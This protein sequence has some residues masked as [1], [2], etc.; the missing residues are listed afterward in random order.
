MT[1]VT[2]AGAVG[3]ARTWQPDHSAFPALDGIRALA[4]S[5]VVMTHAAF[6][7]YRY[8][9]GPGSGMLARLDSGVALFF[10]LSGFLLS[11]PWLVAAATGRPYPAV[12]VY[13]WRRARRILPIYWLSVVFAFALLRDNRHVT[14]AD[15]LRHLG[16]VQIY[17][18]GWLKAGLTQTWS[19]CCEGAFYLLLPIFGVLAVGFSRRFGWRPW[20]LL[21]GCG[22]LVAGT[23][24]WYVWEHHAHWSAFTSANFWLPGF[25]SWFA[26]GM[27]MA[28]IEVHL[29][30]RPATEHPGLRRALDLGASAGS[31]WVLAVAAFVV[32][33]TPVGGPVSVGLIDTTQAITRNLLYVVMAMLVVWPAVFGPRTRLAPAQ[34]VFGNRVMRYLGEISYSIFLLHLVILEGVMN[35]LGYHLFTGSATAVFLL[36]MAGSIALSAVTFRFVERPVNSLRR[37]VGARSDRRPHE[38]VTPQPVP[39]PTP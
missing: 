14:T 34:L 9:R 38:V 31:C 7:T 28:V 24:G 37:L 35:L 5:A 39:V 15:W 6:W 20:A 11:R 30:Y 4:V 27:A 18:L 1:S 23:V 32:V 21:G 36:T 3:E 19:L 22:A 12:R 16:L 2:A 17:H 33:S 13:F 8:G 26:G 10:V 29:T 25:L